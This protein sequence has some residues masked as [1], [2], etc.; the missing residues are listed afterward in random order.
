MRIDHGHNY[1]ILMIPQI[2]EKGK[3]SPPEVDYYSGKI[4]SVY[5]INLPIILRIIVIYVCK[6]I[7]CI[8]VVC[9]NIWSAFTKH[10]Y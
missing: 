7:S 1:A 10:Q 5:G 6:D 9:P 8:P 2:L 3:T 4:E